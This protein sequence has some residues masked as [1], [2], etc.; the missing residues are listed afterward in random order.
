MVG[1]K[2]VAKMEEILDDLKECAKEA[3]DSSP[4]EAIIIED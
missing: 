3:A 1:D 4:S 2:T